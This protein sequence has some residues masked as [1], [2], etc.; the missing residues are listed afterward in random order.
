[1][2]GE[3]EQKDAV[4]YSNPLCLFCVLL[5]LMVRIFVMSLYN[6]AVTVHHDHCFMKPGSNNIGF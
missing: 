6:R 4:L 3:V 5:P 1:M 2:V